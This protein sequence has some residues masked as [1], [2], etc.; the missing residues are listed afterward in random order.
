M[1]VMSIALDSILHW[2]EFHSGPPMAMLLP[3]G[4]SDKRG[5]RVLN[6]PLL[7]GF[8]CGGSRPNRGQVDARAVKKDLT[9]FKGR[10]N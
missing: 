8:S 3:Q 10:W 6:C 4:V 9:Q 5:Q 7:L 2:I 1:W